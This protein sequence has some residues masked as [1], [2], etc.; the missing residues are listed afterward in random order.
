M[1][2]HRI[3]RIPLFTALALA[4]TATFAA[5]RHGIIPADIDRKADPCTDFHQYAN[6]AWRAENKIPAE[7]DRWSRRWQSGE[8]NKGYVR[9]I[10]NEVSSKSDWPKGSAE[11]LTGD[12]FAGC[13]NEEKVNALGA[14]PIEPW[15]ADVRAIEDRQGVATMVARMHDVGAFAPFVVYAGEDLHD[16]SQ[17]IAHI[18]AGGLGMP[19]RD[20]YL[21]T[22]KRFVEAREKYLVHVAKMF[23]LAGTK[24][25]AA[26]KNAQTVFEIEKRLA[27]ASLDNV[28]RRDPKQQDHMTAYA[29]LP[30]VAP[31]FDWNANFDATK[32][33]K[34]A[35][36]VTE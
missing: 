21:K 30:K 22:D 1:T 16:P 12:F 26:K 24:P 28:A 27:E 9:D 6:G 23:E 14:A 19:D 32:I 3:A 17:T 15:L 35:L 4:A 2:P 18:Y 29:D 8:T 11:Q 10:L 20:Y 36:N 5:E 34:N 33:P 7:M 31:G 25:D 13:M